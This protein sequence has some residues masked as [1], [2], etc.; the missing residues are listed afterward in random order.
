M[1][2]CRMPR[3]TTVST[4]GCTL[5]VLCALPGDRLLVRA[6]N[7]Q[8]TRL[9][10]ATQV[11]EIY[12]ARSVPES[13]TAPT[14]FCAQQRIGFGGATL[15]GQYTFRSTATQTSDG[16]MIDTNAKKIG[17]IHL[18][19][20]P[21]SDPT[22]SNF[23]GEGFLGRTPFKGIGECHPRKH[24][25]PERGLNMWNCF[26]DLSGLPSAYVG[27]LLTTNTMTSLQSLGMETDPRG[28]TQA[29]IA[30]IRLWKKRAEH[31]APQ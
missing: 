19:V 5:W 26:L 23:Y 29:S 24:D 2:S 4:L 3:L 7:T 31:Q 9:S 6:Q 27:G 15:E 28:Y 13:R 22:I 1:P 20:G 12:I 30:T 21:T 16:R 8:E 25:F 10:A 18:C 14:A 11:E 17:S